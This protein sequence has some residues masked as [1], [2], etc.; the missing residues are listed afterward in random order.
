MLHR[1]RS[2]TRTHRRSLR[3]CSVLF[4]SPP[5]GDDRGGGSSVGRTEEPP[6]QPSP[7]RREG[8]VVISLRKK[9][10]ERP[11]RL[12][13]SQVSNQYCASRD[14]QL[15]VDVQKRSSSGFGSSQMAFLAESEKTIE[16]ARTPGS[17]MM[18][19]T[20]TPGDLHEVG[21][22]VDA[23][24]GRGTRRIRVFGNRTGTPFH[25][26]SLVGGHSPSIT[27]ASG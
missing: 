11:W 9:K 14:E 20:C 5:A 17:S 16:F 13:Y 7:A 25:S 19:A 22:V 12:S 27:P 15:L 8:F 3:G 6:T 18:S 2:T 10:T 26:F 4:P 1:S 23:L 21:R 24:A